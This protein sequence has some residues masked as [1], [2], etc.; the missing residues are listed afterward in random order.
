LHEKRKMG[1]GVGVGGRSLFPKNACTRMDLTGHAQIFPVGKTVKIGSQN[2]EDFSGTARQAC[3]PTNFCEPSQGLGF[4]ET[5][6]KEKKRLE[7]GMCPIG[8][9]APP[10]VNNFA[11]E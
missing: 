1:K 4:F 8:E 6:G 5:A 9:V 3:A 7:K 11:K 2:N 10:M